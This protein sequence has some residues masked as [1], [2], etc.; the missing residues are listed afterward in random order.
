MRGYLCGTTGHSQGIVVAAAVAASDSW[1]AFYKAASDAT[2]LLFWIGLKSQIQSQGLTVNPASEMLSIRGLTRE[3]LEEILLKANS[4][5]HDSEKVTVALIN[6]HTSFVV[7]GSYRS[8][9]GVQNLLDNLKAS[10][11]QDQ[12]RIAHPWRR[13]NIEYTFMPISAPFHSS[14]LAGVGEEIRAIAELETF[15]DLRLGIPLYH[16]CTGSDIQHLSGV[17]L[18]QSLVSM[19]LEEPVEWT[20][21]CIHDKITHI[22]DFGPSRTSTFLQARVEGSGI[23]IILAGELI[24]SSSNYGGKHE[25]FTNTPLVRPSHW[26]SVYA[27][28]IESDPGCQ[29]RLTNRFVQLMGT[30]PIMVAGMTPTT[31]P[32]DFVSSVMKAGYHIELA[33]GGYAQP[34]DLELAIRRLAASIPAN[35]A[36]AINVIYANPRAILWQTQLLSRLIRE[37]LPIEGLTIGAGVPSP[38]V[39]AEYIATLGI[40]Y[41]GLK[42]GSLRGIHEVIAIAE[43]SPDFPILLQWTGGRA[44]GHHSYEDQFEPLLASYALIRACSNITLVVGG[45][46]GDAHGIKELLTGKWSSSFGYAR[47]PVDGVLLGSRLMT[48]KEA[49]TSPRVKELI[50]GIPGTSDKDWFKT[51]GGPA[52]GIITVK[53]EMGEPIHMVAN[54]AALFWRDLDDTIFNVSSQELLT[55]KLRLRRSEIIRRLNSEYCKPW[56]AMNQVGIAV[57]IEDLSYLECLRRCVDLMYLQEQKRWIHASYETIFASL[58]QRT[59]ERLS[60]TASASKDPTVVIKNLARR[61]S[62]E[63]GAILYSEDVQFFINLCQRRGQK[64]VNF[65][66]TLDREFETWFKK[67]SLWQAERLEAVDGQDP[68]RVCII[69]GP[70]A[71]RYSKIINEPASEILGTIV[72]ELTRCLPHKSDATRSPKGLQAPVWSPNEESFSFESCGMAGLEE[73]LRTIRSTAPDW[74]RACLVDNHVVQ[75]S[76]RKANIIPTALKFAPGDVLHVKYDQEGHPRFLSL[77]RKDP[78]GGCVYSAL[79]LQSPDGQRVRVGMEVPNSLRLRKG[80]PLYLDFSLVGDIGSSSRA[81]VDKTPHRGTRIRE[82]Y[83]NLWPADA[84]NSKDT[85]FS[86]DREFDGEEVTLTEQ[87]IRDFVSVTSRAS[88][89]IQTSATKPGAPMDIAII[90]AWSALTKCLLVAELGGE[91]TR[92]LHR[93]NSF[94]LCNGAKGLVVGDML[95]AR[96]RLTKIDVQP[97][98]KSIEVLATIYRQNKPAIVMHSSFFIPGRFTHDASMSVTMSS[99]KLD[100]NSPVL[101]HLLKSRRWLKF[102][103]I[104]KS[105]IGHTLTFEFS[106]RET[107]SDAPASDCFALAVRGVVLCGSVHVAYVEFSSPMCSGNPVLDFL[108]RWAAPEASKKALESPG[109]T[110]SDP[111][112][113]HIADL[114]HEYSAL[115]GDTNPIHTCAPFAAFA[116]LDRPILHGMYTSAVCRHIFAQHVSAHSNGEFHRWSTSFEGKVYGNDELRMEI[117][118][119]AMMKGNMLMEIQVSRRATGDIVLKAEAEIEQQGSAY[120]FCGQGSQE[121]GM[122]MATYEA[123]AAARRVWDRG[124]RHL[125]ELYGFSILDIVKKN[126]TSLTVYFSG[127]RGRKLLQNYLSMTKTVDGIAIPVARGLNSS[128]TSYSFQN[129]AGILCSTQFAQPAISLMNLAEA[130]SLEA[131]G[132]VPDKMMFAGHSLGEYSALSACADVFSVE[133]LMSLTFYRGM[134]MQNSLEQDA[135]G[136]TP[137]SMSA[138][139]P[140]R[141]SVTFDEAGLVRLVHKVS[142]AT[143]LLLEV[144][145]YNIEGHQYVCAG[146]IKSLWVLGH[147]CDLMVSTGSRDFDPL[148]AKALNECIETYR[149]YLAEKIN[150]EHIDPEKLVGRYIPNLTGKPFSLEKSFVQEIANMTGSKPLEKLLAAW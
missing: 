28:S 97:T 87:M 104:S 84:L 128:S 14:L 8:L 125:M 64:P 41:I 147:V 56:F 53:S 137:Y 20:K 134:V 93:S 25:L 116:E 80:K 112:I 16:T 121:T 11:D 66:P 90:I 76:M 83:F 63:L 47:M 7:C 6:S 86:F 146:H 123:D 108:Q 49:H 132:V 140:A 111:I 91:L 98:G 77:L 22:V 10:P 107:R 57:D 105:L 106:S 3:V 109:L 33:A 46:F 74:L 89:E 21:A 120:V 118:H 51:Y 115:S 143:G 37:G 9:R 78:R 15:S 150:K 36:I 135:D 1:E 42:P 145:N 110:S 48:A 141:V 44:G 81:L 73:A 68:Q 113:F 94:E 103:D 75:G 67:D 2:T 101:E 60:I 17:R 130:A 45:G 12:S 92:L 124:D 99:I 71:A 50:A 117:Q 26:V 129:P 52:G 88:S 79:S 133:E 149:S 95:K 136:R 69:H 102:Q 55:K 39:A 126:P 19:I 58:L 96:A 65:I 4:Y 18:T 40:K 54:R 43:K 82:F 35:R 61:Y 100:V 59:L 138:V 131:L 142:T 72:S 13:P 144:V 34:Q 70:V 29:L 122:G 85:E 30:P 127:R 23:R 139:N 148:I 62:S 114:G 24:D 31:M 27:P 32:W 119:T 5:F 38:D